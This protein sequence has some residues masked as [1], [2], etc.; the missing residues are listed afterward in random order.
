MAENISSTLNNRLSSPEVP[1]Q[2]EY[3]D[4]EK[5]NRAMELIKDSLEKTYVSLR[6]LEDVSNELEGWID[7]TYQTKEDYEQLVSQMKNLERGHLCF[8]NTP[9]SYILDRDGTS[10]DVCRNL[11]DQVVFSTTG[12][13][14]LTPAGTIGADNSTQKDLFAVKDT[15]YK[16]IQLELSPAK[17]GVSHSFYIDFAVPQDLDFFHI[18]ALDCEL[19]HLKCIKP[20]GD[21]KD[22]SED[23]FLRQK[24]VAAIIFTLHIQ[25]YQEIKNRVT[26]YLYE[27]TINDLIIK[28]GE[29]SKECGHIS[30]DI[31]VPSGTILELSANFEE[32]D[33]SIEFYITENG[34]DI[35]IL[36]VEQDKIEQEKV[37]YA[38]P[39]RLP[40][41][42]D[43]DK[44]KN[45]TIGYTPEIG[46]RHTVFS[47]PINVK[48]IMRDYGEK[49]PVLYKAFLRK[50]EN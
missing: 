1:M 48:V 26:R 50:A 14:D 32:N 36:P 39:T 25:K 40:S 30:Q 49:T 9:S 22:F 18:D 28:R 12:M 10:I 7:S 4:S 37:F 3:L 2:D 46:W 21:S 27:F 8:F 29:P 31:Q 34:R 20:N 24:N 35:P 15:G 23:G 33:G 47:S 11:R 19:K 41:G 38:M 16:S 5:F 43:P 6:K 42:K 17:D 44:Y 13:A 45:S